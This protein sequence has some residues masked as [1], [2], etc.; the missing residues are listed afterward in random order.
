VPF[1]LLQT[2]AGRDRSECASLH[3]AHKGTDL[4][5]AWQILSAKWQY[6]G[7]HLSSCWELLLLKEKTNPKQIALI[8]C[9]MFRK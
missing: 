8:W 6:Q 9:N 7:L 5:S 2:A 1:F 4:A 3:F